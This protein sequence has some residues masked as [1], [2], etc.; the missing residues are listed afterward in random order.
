VKY[1]GFDVYEK[2]IRKTDYAEV[3]MAKNGE[4]DFIAVS[5]K[6]PGFTGKKTAGGIF[7]VP[8]T[9][10]NA[11]VLRRVFPFT[12]PAKVLG[13]ERTFGLGDRLGIAAPGHIRII[14]KYDC[15][16]VLAQQSMR[17]LLLTG[18]S[19]KDVLDAASFAVFREG[20]TKGFGADGDHLKTAR[21]VKHA[22]S[23]G[24]TIITLDCS[25][26]IKNDITEDN[27]PPLTKA[28]AA[29]YLGK[30]FDIGEGIV[31]RFTEGELKKAAAVYGDAVVFAADIYRRFFKKGKSGADLE[32]SI[33][34]TALPTSPGQHYFAARELLDSGLVFATLAPRFCGEFQKGVDYR[35]NL[36]QFDREIKIHAAI[37]RHFG[38][39][40]SIHSGSDKFSV[41]PAIGKATRGIFHVKTA[42]TS[43]L[44]AM[45]MVSKLDAALYR[46]IHRYA[47]SVFN[48]AK[49]HYVIS[50]DPSTLKDISG[51][52][53]A[54]LPALFEND[55]ARQLIHITYGFILQKKNP[56]GSFLFR[57]RLYKLWKQ[58]EDA[59]AEAL[60]G[61]IGRHLDLLG[62]RKE[63]P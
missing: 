27:A 60:A 42:G 52:P 34:E 15:F 43:W 53:D 62:I 25:D 1:S 46:E 16:P 37:A 35:G 7:R 17:E 12:S 58:N 11:A 13:K 18:R 8:L 6:N 26:Y 3:F 5:G 22:L 29:K 45:R 63:A 14:E 2:S 19:Y 32:I 51:V 33:D 31:I 9:H 54:E 41:F 24:F 61:H 39:K 20:F 10:K 4:G 23:L 56:D 57:E 38:Y 40:L 50:A 36:N 59:Y 48:E 30:E 21:D 49:K 28:C 47:L 44:E 55:T